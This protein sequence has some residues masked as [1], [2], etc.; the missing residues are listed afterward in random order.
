MGSVFVNDVTTLRVSS[1]EPSSTMITS[2]SLVGTV[3]RVKLSSIGRNKSERLYVDTTAAIAQGEATRPSGSRLCIRFDDEERFAFRKMRPCAQ[4]ALH[5][6]VGGVPA[7]FGN[8]LPQAVRNRRRVDHT[9]LE[10]GLAEV[11][12]P[13]EVI[14]PSHRGAFIKG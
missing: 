3:C 12:S 2:N 7:V 9:H 11:A 4:E 1:V 10:T 6:V 14:A 8:R 13:Y 5:L